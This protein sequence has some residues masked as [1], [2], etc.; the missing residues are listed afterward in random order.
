MSVNLSPVAGAAAQFLDNAGNVLTGGKLFTY[1][2]GTTTPAAVYTDSTGTAFH[3]NPIILDAAGRVPAGG[4]IWLSDNIS[5]KFVLKDANDVLIATWDNII[6][7]NS[8]FVNYTVQEEI[9]TATAGQTVFNLTTVTYAPGTNSLQVF[10]DGVNQYDGVAYAFV[11]TNATTVTFTAGLHVGA[12]VKF[13]TAVPATGTATN[14]NVVVYDPAGV[15][16]VTT[17]VQTKLRETVSVK[18]FGAVG[19]GVTDDT[20]AI[21]AAIDS[22]Y[23]NKKSVYIPGGTYL[24]SSTIFA[25]GGDQYF[26]NGS[27]IYGDGRGKTIIKMTGAGLSVQDF[28]FSFKKDVG[29]FATIWNVVLQDFTVE[30]QNA[31]QW[32]GIG[33]Y[34]TASRID[35]TNVDVTG[36]AYRAVWFDV[37]YVCNFTNMI[38][39]CTNSGIRIFNT[40]TTNRYDNIG[41]FG[42]TAY[43]FQ[44][45][46]SYS[47]VGNVF[48]ENCSGVLF[49]LFFFG[50]SI[51]SLGCE[52]TSVFPTTVIESSFSN[53]N[54]DTLYI[55]GVD[56]TNPAYRTISNS[57]DAYL[58]IDTI[59]FAAPGKVGT[60]IAGSFL[61][62]FNGDVTINNLNSDVDFT[63]STDARANNASLTINGPNSTGVSFDRGNR[64]PFIGAN[65]TY[66]NP[67]D[68][69]LGIYGD[70]VKAI[71]LDSY[72]SIDAG[73]VAGATNYAGSIPPSKGDLFIEN[74]PAVNMVA[75][76]ICT[77]VGADVGLSNALPIPLLLAG[78]TAQRP[79]VPA[80]KVGVMYFDTTLN[81]PVWWNGSSWRDATGSVA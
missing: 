74:D 22:A 64:R 71:Y 63:T 53:T 43:A 62:Q 21:Q 57:G 78:T 8:N 60:T 15:G 65:R 10:V 56:E 12:L 32:S 66:W 19:D 42:S 14:A 73:G 7:I 20:V 24:I 46:G 34:G 16:A 39:Y 75:G 33:L 45:S 80:S 69:T 55:L 79:T 41:V 51:Q 28:A 2:A 25:Y 38:L 13:T 23:T 52:N 9:Q 70:Q 29:V 50:G 17:N 48:A 68:G 54:V 6:G 27:L 49:R 36:G 67:L 4:E 3:A 40:G 76:Y 26:D 77:F 35:I 81:K 44:F 30:I 47:S 31:G 11:E 72:G 37:A 1:L 61:N 59:R 58:S 18:D 5:Y